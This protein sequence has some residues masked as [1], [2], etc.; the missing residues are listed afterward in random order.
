MARVEADNIA[1]A[2][3]GFGRQQRMRRW[4]GSGTRRRQDSGVLKTKSTT[5]SK[6]S[7]GYIFVFQN[8][9]GLCVLPNRDKNILGRDISLIYA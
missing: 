7:Y 5:R 8:I 3:N 2:L 9:I 6:R 1:S 4:R